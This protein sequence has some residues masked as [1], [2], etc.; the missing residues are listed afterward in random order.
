VSCFDGVLGVAWHA[1]LLGV[2]WPIL[3]SVGRQQDNSGAKSCGIPYMMCM[4][5]ADNDKGLDED[6]QRAAS[7][8]A[9]QAEVH[10]A[11]SWQP[12]NSVALGFDCQFAR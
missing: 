12:G 8:P 2:A 4:S 1:G 7:S 10:L 9:E 5:I 11:P 3:D 6:A